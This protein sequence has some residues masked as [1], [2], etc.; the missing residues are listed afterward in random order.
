MRVREIW[1]IPSFSFKS[2]S[3]AEIPQL[4]RIWSDIH[5][6]S[7]PFVAVFVPKRIW[8]ISSR[9]AFA[10]RR[11]IAPIIFYAARH[12]SQFNPDGT[13]P[14][15]DEIES[16]RLARCA[17]NIPRDISRRKQTS[18]EWRNRLIN[19]PR[20]LTRSTCSS[21]LIAFLLLSPRRRNDT[22]VNIAAELACTGE[23][24]Y[25]YKSRHTT[26]AEIS[27]IYRRLSISLSTVY[28]QHLVHHDHI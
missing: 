11:K 2:H 28:P 19:E 5:E 26:S 17:N 24:M 22:R 15:K 18:R 16:N 6:R 21:C 25:T 9:C 12:I 23:H 8:P 7:H 1:A 4:T 13:A 10:S 27:F 3:P 14:S 20:Y